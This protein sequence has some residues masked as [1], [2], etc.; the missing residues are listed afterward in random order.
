MGLYLIP[1]KTSGY[2]ACGLGIATAYIPGIQWFTPIL[3]QIS[4]KKADI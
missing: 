3:A 1:F 4:P 2:K